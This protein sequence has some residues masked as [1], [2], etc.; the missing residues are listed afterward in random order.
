MTSDDGKVPAPASERPLTRWALAT[1]A[2][3]AV[4]VVAVL[5]FPRPL[6]S[7]APVR[8]RGAITAAITVHEHAVFL[9]QQ[10]DLDPRAG[11]LIIVGPSGP[12]RAVD[13]RVEPS[14]SA[15]C[16]M[17]QRAVSSVICPADTRP[18]QSPAARPRTR[19]YWRLVE[20]IPAPRTAA[21]SRSMQ[22]DSSRVAPEDQGREVGARWVAGQTSF[23]REDGAA[24]VG[25]QTLR[26]TSDGVH[27]RARVG[28]R[29]E[30]PWVIVEGRRHW[31]ERDAL[32]EHAI[33][34]RD[35]RG[36]ALFVATPDGARIALSPRIASERRSI[37]AT[38]AGRLGD[39]AGIALLAWFMAQVTALAAART[40]ESSTFSS[41]F[42]QRFMRW[43][44]MLATFVTGALALAALKLAQG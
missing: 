3:D 21:T 16:A 30:R 34:V 20:R 7:E 41:P 38:L 8:A 15:L 13:L 24:S 32:F 42:W 14:Q 35:A 40:T 12:A 11:T 26:V 37:F 17:A 36:E 5:R 2:A 4:L 10:S 27:L 18:E 19:T 33:T 22:P 9:R 23:E 28:F 29:V 6:V 39:L 44:A 31:I 43:S 1:L 25:D